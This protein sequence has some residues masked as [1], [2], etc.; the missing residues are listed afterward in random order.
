MNSE[1]FFATFLDDARKYAP[2]FFLSSCRQDNEAGVV[3]VFNQELSRLGKKPLRSVK[4]RGHG[5]D[6]PDCEASDSLGQR[7]G[8]EV[9]ELVDGDSI[10]AEKEGHHVC[11][12][13]L[14]PS[15]AIS[16]IRERIRKKDRAKVKGGPY[17]QYI[18]IIC[19]DDPRFL[20][21][22]TLDAVPS[23]QFGATNLIDAAY[24]LQSYCPFKKCC[25]VIELQ[26]T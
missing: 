25:P 4:L 10:A 7:V 19:C 14:T 2:Y 8:I 15:E 20:S 5:N 16:A 12:L 23:A 9:T 1:N 13:A 22:E 24:L 21:Y 18:L 26:L 3:E 11:Q 6:P 17:H